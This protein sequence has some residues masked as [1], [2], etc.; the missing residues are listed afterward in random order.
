MK[1]IVSLLLILVL[2]ITLASCKEKTEI[3]T[4]EPYEN[5]LEIYY[6]NDF[7]GA[8][9]PD[10]DQL[11]ISYIANLIN[12]KKEA[13]PEN[14][15]F[16]VGGDMLQGSALSNYY[17]GESTIEL[18][19]LSNLDAFTIGNHEFDWG[20]ETVA[21]YKDGNEENGEANFPFLGA[22]VFY[23]GTT[24]IPDF[25]DPYT[26]IE[27]GDHKIGIIGTIGYGLEY[28][29]AQSR[30]DDYEFG[31]PLDAIEEY[32]Y[33][34]RTEEDCDMIIVVAHDGGSSLNS[35][36]TALEGDYKVDAVFNGHTHS[37]YARLTSGT[38]V[39]Q[40]GDNGEF[41]GY[42]RWD[43]EETGTIVE[44]DNLDYFSDALLSTPDPAVE[45]LLQSYILETSDLLDTEIMV[46]GDY[47]SS[48][49]LSVW[50]AELVREATNS[51]VGLQNGGG[52]RNSIDDGQSITLSTLYQ[53]WPFDNVIKTVMLPGSVVK[54]LVGDY[55]SST[56][57]SV[58]DN[59][60]LYKVAVNDYSFDKTNSAF[61][62][63][64]DITNTG[65]VLR[66]LVQDELEL[67]TVLYTNFFTTNSILTIY[68][69]YQTEE[70]TTNP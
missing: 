47:Y 59:N 41:V 22:N 56:D 34:L 3:E 43:F 62:N 44:F 36:V 4:E 33:Y 11:G 9:T 10:D 69:T 8:L 31:S 50:L 17:A 42:V 65:I 18:L 26:I 53:I 38:P 60:T 67:Q 51:D 15:L 61:Q 23:K 37:T 39:V 29:I 30:I 21:N 7:H 16:I 24:D 48:G 32:S 40:S 28:S 64:E 58:F 54:N 12:T 14:V 20:L 1:K 49:D 19:N 68:S 55:Y 57:I 63:G 25:I 27:K 6:L 2:S 70:E 46:S 35:Q 52:T 13:N 45:A 5:Y 66:D